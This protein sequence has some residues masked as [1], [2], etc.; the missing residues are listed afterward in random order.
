M[1]ERYIRYLS[2]HYKNSTEK[3][4]TAKIA[5]AIKRV[6][7]NTEFSEKVLEEVIDALKE[8]G[9]TKAQILAHLNMIDLEYR[10]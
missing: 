2:A 6:K 8:E 1:K 10:T 5:A 7:E 9:Y 4:L 3:A